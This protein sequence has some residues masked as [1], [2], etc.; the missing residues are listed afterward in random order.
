M[1]KHSLGIVYKDNNRSYVDLLA[2]E[3]QIIYY[4]LKIIQS[5][6]IELYKVKRNLSNRI[7]CT[8]Y[9]LLPY[10]D[11]AALIYDITAGLK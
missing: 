8:T 1:H 2:N 3:V 10:A 6:A 9:S 7:K 11:L 5:L 4:S